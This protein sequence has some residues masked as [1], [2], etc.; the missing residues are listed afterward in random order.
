MNFSRQIFEKSLKYQILCKTVQWQPSCSMRTD[1]RKDM[2]KITVAFPNFCER[3]IKIH[4]IYMLNLKGNK[5]SFSFFPLVLSSSSSYGVSSLAY[6]YVTEV[7][8]SFRNISCSCL[9]AFFFFKFLS[10]F[11]TEDEPLS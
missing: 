8:R 7:S 5:F 3:A 1:R 2:K 9:F 10:I 6:L 4:F 11:P